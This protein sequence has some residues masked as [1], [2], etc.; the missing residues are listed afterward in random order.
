MVV[1]PEMF[2]ICASNITQKGVNKIWCLNSIT[3]G[4][5]YSWML[6]CHLFSTLLRRVFVMTRGLR[7][8]KNSLFYLSTQSLV[9]WFL[10]FLQFKY[11]L[12]LLTGLHSQWIIFL[13]HSTSNFNLSTWWI[14][15]EEY[16]ILEVK[17]S[18]ISAKKNQR[19]L[20]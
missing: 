6:V 10:N 4:F 15:G 19:S 12:A 14:P 7:K 9:L 3:R 17:C 13:I 5:Q 8:M 1:W 11:M 16:N 20:C 18:K 2:Y